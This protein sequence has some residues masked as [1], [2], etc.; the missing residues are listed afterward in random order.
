MGDYPGQQPM[1][2]AQQGHGRL[3]RHRDAALIAAADHTNTGLDGTFTYKKGQVIS[4]IA[5]LD[6][7]IVEKPGQMP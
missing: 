6:L 1:L 2:R 7:A 5:L 4:W 3:R